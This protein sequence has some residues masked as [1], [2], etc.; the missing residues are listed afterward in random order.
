MLKHS[1]SWR[2]VWGTIVTL[3]FLLSVFPILLELVGATAG[4]LISVRRKS[5]C[6]S[7]F[8]VSATYCLH[9]K[10]LVFFSFCLRLELMTEPYSLMLSFHLSWEDSL[11]C[12]IMPQFIIVQPYSVFSLIMKTWQ[13]AMQFIIWIAS[14]HSLKTWQRMCCR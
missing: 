2:F 9:Q 11:S 12:L 8:T 5:H 14:A 6:C 4:S 10:S 7:Q 3:S 1:C 13:Y